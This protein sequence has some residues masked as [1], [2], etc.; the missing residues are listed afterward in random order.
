VCDDRSRTVIVTL[1]LILLA[2]ACEG[3]MTAPGEDGGDADSDVDADSDA[4]IDLSVCG[5]PSPP[6]CA[7]V[8]DACAEVIVGSE[9]DPA[10]CDTLCGAFRDEVVGC[11]TTCAAAGMCEEASACLTASTNEGCERFC[12][13]AR[14]RCDPSVWETLP[15]EDCPGACASFSAET[16]ACLVDMLEGGGC[17]P[18]TVAGCVLGGDGDPRCAELCAWA[19]DATAGCDISFGGY[20]ALACQTACDANLLLVSDG[21]CPWTAMDAGDCD[22]LAACGGVFAGL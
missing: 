22:A 15:R 19:T 10:L 21:D 9:V 13:W 12:T 2:V 5:E 11:L 17:S 20:G 6:G 16:Q 8:C 1:A 18:F 7:L 3:R 4:D 14:G